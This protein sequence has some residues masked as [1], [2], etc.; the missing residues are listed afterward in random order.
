ME[1]II[2]RILI[3]RANNKGIEVVDRNF[4]SANLKGL[5]NQNGDIKVIALNT[6]LSPGERNFTL[7]HELGHDELHRGKINE[8]LYFNNSDYLKKL[9]NEADDYA[10]TLINKIKGMNKKR[11]KVSV[12]I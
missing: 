7:A 12:Q 5:Y 3:D 8:E 9:E 2:Y 4:R 10:Y 11:Y 6:S 1:E